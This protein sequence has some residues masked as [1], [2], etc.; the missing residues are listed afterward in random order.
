MPKEEGIDMPAVHQPGEPDRSQPGE[1]AGSNNRSSSAL[2]QFVAFLAAATAGIAGVQLLL[3]SQEG[4]WQTLVAAGGAALSFVLMVVAWALVRRGKPTIAAYCALLGVLIV[5]G[6]GELSLAGTTWYFLAGGLLLIALLG[7]IASPRKWGQWL[8][9]AGLHVS[10]ILLINWLEPLPRYSSARLA[11]LNVQ[12][13]GTTALLI[14]VVLWEVIR[15]LRGIGTIRT[16]LLVSF[17]GAVT[18]TAF[19]VGAASLVIGFQ[20]S[21]QQVIGSLELVTSFKRS[22]IVA[23]RQDLAN[24]LADIAL[25]KG[26]ETTISYALTVLKPPSGEADVD[27][28][29]NAL[30]LGLQ[31][32]IKQTGKF[33]EM[34]V[35]D[36]EGVVAVATD[37]A[38]EGLDL[39]DQ[40][41]YSFGRLRPHFQPPFTSPVTGQRVMVAA[42]PISDQ[43]GNVVG[44]L[45]GRVGLEPLE[46]ILDQETRLGPT[47]VTYL[48]GADYAVLPTSRRGDEKGYTMRSPGIESALAGQGVGAAVYRDYRDEPVVGAYRWMLIFEGSLL[49]EQPQSVAFGAVYQTLA[50]SIGVVAL[51]VL[52]AV[53]ASL[54]LTRSIANPLADLADTAAQVAAGDLSRMARVEREDEIGVLAQAFNSMT[55]QLRDLFAG[56]EQRISERT[57]E[58]TRRSQ[59]LEAAAEVGRAAS[60]ILDAD[61]LIRQAVELICERFDLYYVALFLVDEAN[62]AAVLQA[63][64]GNTGRPLPPLGRRL[65]VGEGSMIGWCIA[66]RQARIALEAKEDTVRLEQLELPDTRSEAALPLR[67]R[68]QV[69]GAISVQHTEPG[70]FDQDTVV[71]LQTMAD[72]LAVALD[73]ARLFADR[74]QALASIQRAYG[75][76]SRE[77]WAEIL[78]AQPDLGF[79][80]DEHGIS[81]AGAT[82]RPEMEQAM[83]S[84]QTV[85]GNGLDGD[86]KRTLAV[87]IKVRGQVVGVLDTYK[88]AEAGDWT[89]D[90][91]TLLESIAEQLDTALESARLYQDTQRRAAREAAIRRV[92][93]EMR[94]AVDI[95]AILQNTVSEL[96]KALGA[97]RAYVRLGTDAESLSGLSGPGDRQMADGFPPDRT[98]EDG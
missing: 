57:R 1:G 30:R 59:Y 55:A 67:S 16:R 45:A 62:E 54:L 60:S 82:W 65:P 77:A 74:E 5:Y 7:R 75:E 64:A 66:N 76:L 46:A 2:G 48:V 73:N 90:E 52:L 19:T 31:E 68:G 56:L 91:I 92:T 12:L 40:P 42:Q 34:F 50:I 14:L 72:Q 61:D 86:G 4:A 78:R 70:A 80:S 98:G 36:R 22:Q 3:Y 21:R 8:I 95:E 32:V 13:V 84:G 79:R 28:A 51:F 41:Y 33:D 93:E 27:S 9:A 29:K 15:I 89:Q 26:P 58:L 47:V 88:P 85:R 87:P 94:R 20:N 63:H 83:R 38:Q 44:I 25:E 43:F 11:F 81:P 96:A 97:P 71:V 17:V 35:L 23:W 6:G 37:S 49:S 18:L 53:G 10:L 24:E 39:S 69:L